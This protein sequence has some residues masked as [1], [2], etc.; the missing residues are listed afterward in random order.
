VGLVS[1]VVLGS[2]SPVYVGEYGLF[3]EIY[4]SEDSTAYFGSPRGCNKESGCLSVFMTFLT[5]KYVDFY[6]INA[7]HQRS[8]RR[9]AVYSTVLDVIASSAPGIK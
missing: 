3:F 8:Q 9:Y 2:H 1:P 4:C 5:K 7:K 6:K